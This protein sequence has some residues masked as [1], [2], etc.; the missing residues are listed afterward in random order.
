MPPGAAE[1]LKE[2]EA[3]IGNKL[4]KTQPDYV[5]P[6]GHNT[7]LRVCLT[8]KEVGKLGNTIIARNF[9]RSLRYKKCLVLSDV[10]LFII[11]THWFMLVHHK[12]NL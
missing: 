10:C 8:R 6:P 9:K 4:L 2:A 5:A 7:Q 11:S 3:S 1:A 12:E